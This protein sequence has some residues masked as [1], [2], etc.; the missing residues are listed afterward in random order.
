MWKKTLRNG[1]RGLLL[2]L[3]LLA[4]APAA[5]SGTT[6][7][8]L[9][10]YDRF[11]L[12]PSTAP[13]S[14]NN[15]ALM[16]ALLSDF[17]PEG[18]AVTRRVGEPATVEGFEALAAETFAGAEEED[19]S[20]IYLSTH[21]LL[22]KGGEG[23]GLALLLSDGVRDE[24]LEPERIRRIL[25]GIPGKKILILDACHAGAAICDGQ[26]AES[27]CFRD[28][29]YR[30]LVS[31]GAEEES[32]FWN[33]EEDAYTG[34]GYF[35]A[36]LNAALR[37]SDPEQIDP[38]GSGE[39]NLQEITRRLREIHGASTVYCWPED[40]REPLFFLPADRKA[41]SLLRGLRFGQVRREGDSL[42]LPI[43][44][45]AEEQVRLVYQL[46][47]RRSGRWDFGH[48][49]R[50][51]DREKTG[52]ARGLLSPGEK[53]RT[54]RLTEKSIG[55]EGVALMQI[56]SLEGEERLPA[57]EAGYVIRLADEEGNCPPG[58]E[59]PEGQ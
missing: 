44:F 19:T 2:A 13:A 14:A 15:T 1:L 6:R 52:L 7:C 21:G 55:E 32:W 41:G 47:P 53:D 9:I 45:R 17:L 24:V 3:I 18:T 59:I 43:H 49:V 4:A 16:E 42:L 22:L 36:A 51:P 38:E 34:T 48:A 54:I 58:Q 26:D 31:C 50:L 56:I 40:S 37:A 28:G 23:S 33:A 30:V 20:L 46:T 25:D 57:A 5:A 8:L 29:P 35:T 12:M 39:V 27:N 10:G 11:F